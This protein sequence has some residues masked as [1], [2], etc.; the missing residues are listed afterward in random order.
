MQEIFASYYEKYINV[1][2]QVIENSANELPDSTEYLRTQI[3]QH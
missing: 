1:G 3:S 2:Y